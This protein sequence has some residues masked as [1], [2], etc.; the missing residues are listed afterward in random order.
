MDDLSAVIGVMS[1]THGN[2]ALMFRA[3]D[4]MLGRFGAGRIIHLGDDWR[5]I[6]ELEAAGYPVWGV[7][8][9]WCDEYANRARRVRT[10]TAAGVRLCFAHSL[11]DAERERSGAHILLFGHT[12]EAELGEEG[13]ALY[14]NPGHLKRAVDR[15][16]RASFGIVTLTPK[17]VVLSIHED[18]GEQRVERHVSRR[19]LKAWP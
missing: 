17:R 7:P 15:D 5:D 16:E 10:E 8:G 11:A 12:H 19:S 13:G 4:T 3:A 14:M 18:G 9:L 2:R 6:T 1:D